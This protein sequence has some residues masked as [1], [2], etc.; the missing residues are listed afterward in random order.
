MKKVKWKQINWEQVETLA[1]TVVFGFRK[2]RSAQDAMEYGF[3]V[4]CRKDSPQWILEE[5]VAALIISAIKG[6]KKTF[7]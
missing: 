6:G 5:D 3:R 2:Y 4:L 1:D 7:Q